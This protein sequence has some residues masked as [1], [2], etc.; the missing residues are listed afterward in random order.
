MKN[1]HVKILMYTRKTWHWLVLLYKD[2]INSDAV[3]I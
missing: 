3:Y 2:M 1:T